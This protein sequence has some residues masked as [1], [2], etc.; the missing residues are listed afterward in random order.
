MITT[1]RKREGTRRRGQGGKERIH[2]NLSRKRKTEAN[3]TLD[4][5][6]LKLRQLFIFHRNLL[7]PREGKRGRE[8]DR[9]RGEEHALRP[10][11]PTQERLRKQKSSITVSLASQ[12][13]VY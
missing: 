1:M 9:Q 2:K 13:S 5:R 12:H 4:S 10:P 11:R 8:G 3:N 6:L 7:G